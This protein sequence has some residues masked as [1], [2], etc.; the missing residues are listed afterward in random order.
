MSWSWPG[1]GLP[2]RGPRLFD[3]TPE[4][5]TS[6]ISQSRKYAGAV[7]RIEILFNSTSTRTVLI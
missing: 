6:E 3:S 7:D 4:H 5:L 1:P 2:S